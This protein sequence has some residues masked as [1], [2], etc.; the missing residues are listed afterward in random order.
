MS[1]APVQS[2]PQT[3]PVVSSSVPET[4]SVTTS[5]LAQLEPI[6]ESIE[7]IAFAQELDQLRDDVHQDAEVAQAVRVGATALSTGLS[8]GYVL[9]LLRGGLL[10]SSLLTSLPAWRFIDPL[11]VLA[12][13]E[14]NPKTDATDDD[15]LEAVVKKGKNIENVEPR[16][17][18]SKGIKG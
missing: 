13:L 8:I 3:E 17:V 15:S 6:I 7:S 10:L 9:W 12:R 4:P 16:D 1:A 5:S 2:Q 11:P 18:V 14:T